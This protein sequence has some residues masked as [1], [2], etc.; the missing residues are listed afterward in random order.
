MTLGQAVLRLDRIGI[1]VSDLP[2][3][4][5]FYTGALGFEASPAVDADARLAGLIGARALRTVMLRRGQ[6][7]LELAQVDPPGAAYPADSRSNDLWFQHCALVTDDI[8]G[9]HRRLSRFPF[10]PIS[11][12]GPQ[13]LPGGVVAFKF[14][15]PDGHPLE[16]IQF[17][18]P[19]P[20]TDGGIDHSAISVADAERSIAFY[21]EQLG[22]SVQTRQVNRGQAQDALD[23]L[24]HVAV[25]VV[26]LAAASPAPHVEL[27][28]YRTPRG[29]PSP[30]AGLSAI[31]AS[32]LIFAMDTLDGRDG[33]I[34]LNDGAQVCMM[35]DQ[36]GHALLL[37]Q[38][39]PVT[40]V[41]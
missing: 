41:L 13:A 31:A 5:A 40:E 21:A 36:D 22:L 18:R 6:Q 3:A 19:D 14:R 16:L 25:D 4:T 34:T 33:V 11:R 37:E 2:A 32:R 7:R 10:T 35:Q 8:A 30:I 39:A 27:L 24:A 38:R 26:A 1:N 23:D 28:S 20:R 9:A 17:P 12:H 29:R 15:D